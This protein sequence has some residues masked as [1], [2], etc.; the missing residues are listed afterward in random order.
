MKID[1]LIPI[2]IVFRIVFGDRTIMQNT[3]GEK[4]QTEIVDKYSSPALLN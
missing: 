2:P 3:K 1:P 4:L